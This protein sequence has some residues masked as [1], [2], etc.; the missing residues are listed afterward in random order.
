VGSNPTPSGLDGG[1]GAAT[2]LQRCSSKGNQSN[3]AATATPGVA[4]ANAGNHKQEQLCSGV[5][6]QT[7]NAGRQWGAPDPDGDEAG[8]YL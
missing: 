5:A 1:G 7:R 6:A 4:A 2:P 3:E 8:G